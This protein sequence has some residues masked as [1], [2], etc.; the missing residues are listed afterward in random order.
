MTWR[1]SRTQAANPPIPNAGTYGLA[2]T[3]LEL[4]RYKEA[5]KYWELIVKAQ[6]KNS[7]AQDAL[8]RARRGLK[9]QAED[10]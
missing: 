1:R 5:V 8:E 2:E 9:E 6:P 3:Y 7:S 10:D 4:G